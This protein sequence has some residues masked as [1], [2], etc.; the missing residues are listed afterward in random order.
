LPDNNNRQKH[1]KTPR[2]VGSHR[3]TPRPVGS[4]QLTTFTF[5]VIN[6]RVSPELLLLEKK[7]KKKKKKKG[8]LRRRFVGEALETHQRGI[9]DSKKWLGTGIPRRQY[10]NQKPNQTET[11]AGGMLELRRRRF[12]LAGDRQGMLEIPKTEPQSQST[13]TEQLFTNNSTCH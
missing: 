8:N 4:Q 6:Q 1:C 2:P 9:G 12:K 10:Q 3:K 13:T 7:K 5:H 11:F